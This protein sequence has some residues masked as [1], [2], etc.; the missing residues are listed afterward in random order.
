MNQTDG[1]LLSAIRVSELLALERDW[2]S[3]SGYLALGG[4]WLADKF[5]ERVTQSD[6]G[7][8]GFSCFGGIYF[9]QTVLIGL[10][11]NMVVRITK[12]IPPISVPLRK[13]SSLEL[14]LYVVDV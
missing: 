14:I 11:L 4:T 8:S 6:T 7:T 3:W 5:L 10:F 2:G 1:P 12:L 9:R 13:Q